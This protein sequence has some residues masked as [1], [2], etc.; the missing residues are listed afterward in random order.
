MPSVARRTSALLAV[1]VLAAFAAIA[2]TGGDGDGPEGGASRAGASDPFG[3][4]PGR[5]DELA[6]AAA[7]G[8]A[9][10]LYAKSP[11]GA[12]ASAERTAQLRPLVE[13]AANGAGLDPDILEAI[14]LLESAGR[15]DAAADPRLDGAVGLTQILAETG[16]NLL[17]MTVDPAGAR[18]IGRSL[19]RAQQRGDEA[20]V[21]RLEARRRR[22]D[23]R[24]DP[25]KAL[26][27]TARYL[28]T[29]RS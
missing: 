25:Q 28:T 13:A 3:Y 12:R 26:S 15:A 6:A 19:R 9:H 4:T 20:L 8:H 10:V 29:S 23:E 14:V 11:G 1:A 24:F 18:R 17:G 22:V 21:Q 2:L 27:G 5:E 16:R 7:R